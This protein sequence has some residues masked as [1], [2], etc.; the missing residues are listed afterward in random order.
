MEQIAILR[1]P[2]ARM[3]KRWTAGGITP[4][5]D[6]KYFKARVTTLSDIH[7]LSAE[8]QHLEARSSDCVIRGQYIGS[9]RAAQEDPE[10]KKGRVRRTLA[11]FEDVP[12]HICL[13]EVDTYEPLLADPVQDPEECIEEFIFAMLPEAFRGV[14]YHWQL[15]N[16]AGAPG[17][18]HLLKAHIWFWLATPYTSVEMRAWGKVTWPDAATRPIDLSVFNP[19]QIHYTASP[20]FEEGIEDPVPVRSGF[21]AGVMDEEVDLQLGDDILA[22]AAAMAGKDTRQSVLKNAI[23]SDPIVQLLD[24]KGMVKSR[25][26]AGQ[27]FIHCP[28]EDQHTSDG[29]P[30]S[31]VYYPPN[32]G[33]YAKGAFVCLHDHCRDTPQREF[34]LALG[35][36]DILE[37]FTDLGGAGL[38][39]DAAA[40]LGE[41]PEGVTFK[42]IPE[43]QHLTT[44]LANA[45][46]IL[47]KF[48]GRLMVAA[49]RWYAWAGTHWAQDEGEVYTAAVKLSKIIKAEADD[50]KLKALKV[51]QKRIAAGEEGKT[52]TLKWLTR[53]M[54]DK[55]LVKELPE[56]AIRD[57]VVSEALMKWA[58]RSEM[59]SVIDAALYIARKMLAIP[60]E[61][62]D[63]D[64]WALNC[65]NGTVDLRT[66]DM[67]PHRASD[68]ITHCV[69]MAYDP[70]AEAP[71]W[72]RVLSQITLEDGV[73][74]RPVA[75][76]LQRWFGYC[77]TASTREQCFVVHWG[78]GGNGKSTVLGTIGTLL[79]G[80][81]GTAAPGLL[82]A[83]RA[84]SHPT[85][86][87]S[88]MGKRMV[89]A[90][91]S[92]EG[93]VLREGF[94]KQATG[95]DELSARFMRGDFFE[96]KPTHKIQ[97]LTNHRPIIKGQDPGIWRRILLV[98]YL[99]K[100]GSEAEVRAGLAQ[101][102]KDMSVGDALRREQQG[103]LTWLVRGAVIWFHEGLNPPEAVLAASEA[104]KGE[105]D[106]VLQFITECCEVGQTE[107]H[108]V[109]LAGPF[110][111][112]YPAYREWCNEGGI[113]PLAKN[114]MLAEV[115]R[116][117]PKLAKNSVQ[118]R[119]EFNKKRRI[120]QLEG[121]RLLDD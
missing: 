120:L 60:T 58:A 55:E 118:R 85:E 56:A 46:R 28:C 110:G 8:L 2:T 47:R 13:I 84:D 9:E 80:Y 72:E 49:D 54:A 76:F 43:A 52:L 104:Y 20:S 111:G 61:R 53:Q 40:L 24:E 59:R 98:P 41:S 88:L 57:W 75:A 74:V 67:R 103:I 50:W 33:G 70:E 45:E 78:S 23:D 25:G 106:R 68:Y 14:S 117:V 21:V 109:P 62:L 38:P 6:G 97:L 36:D 113:K 4:Y 69:P 107:E 66:G 30:T 64:P 90:H 115:E 121:I 32:T 100:F 35:Y 17:K 93:A 108:I 3:A 82:T 37:E 39:D 89:T 73:K 86:I 105:Q 16:S 29:G 79:N 96:F 95:E 44:D 116:V 112:L 48:E 5:D 102:V 12:R 87:A 51:C 34:Q 94:V 18:A 26:Q 114:R 22:Q 81:A 65:Q 91:E 99:A 31:T 92:D 11:N 27:L 83:R 7:A 19:V 119:D 10:Y 15:S 1:H 63:A 77:A 42:Q 101:H 71:T